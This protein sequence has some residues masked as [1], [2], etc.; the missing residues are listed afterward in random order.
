MQGIW[1]YPNINRKHSIKYSFK[2]L[3]VVISSKNTLFVEFHCNTSRKLVFLTCKKMW[4]ITISGVD[5]GKQFG[6][7]R[8]FH[9]VSFHKIDT[10]LFFF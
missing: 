8:T 3:L 10:S 2:K 7:I 5:S 4:F 1:T 9:N 6:L